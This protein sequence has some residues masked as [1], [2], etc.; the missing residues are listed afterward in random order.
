MLFR[1]TNIGR[2]I[3]GQIPM[4]KVANKKTNF[5]LSKAI[6]IAQGLSKVASYQYNE[7]VYQSVQ[8]MMKI[9]SE[10][11]IE[12]KSAFDS[13]IEKNAQLEKAADVQC[14]VEDM[15]L[16]GLVGEHDVHEKIADLMARTPD[17][18]EI[19]KEAVKLA[20]CG[21]SGNIFSS[22]VDNSSVKTASAKKSGMFDDIIQS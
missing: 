14:I 1:E 20:S 16:N 9:A 21:K 8:E 19:F 22:E 11:L 3:L 12:L 17:K 7:K 4:D 10:C 5:D 18:L 6:G 13:A 15:M 2:L